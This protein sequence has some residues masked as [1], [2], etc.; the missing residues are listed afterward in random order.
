MGEAS[1]VESCSFG[2]MVEHVDSVV[3]D[4]CAGEPTV[5]LLFF[6]CDGGGKELLGARLFR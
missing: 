5:V 2:T 6:V 4:A 3:F 1:R